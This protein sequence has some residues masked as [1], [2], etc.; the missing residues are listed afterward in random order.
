MPLVKTLTLL[1]NF[2]KLA[3]LTLA[4][5]Q[6]ALAA[7]NLVTNPGF[8][9]GDFTGWT[10]SGNTGFT[11]V[12]SQ[13][14]RSGNFAAFFG[15]IE[16]LGFI[17]QSL[18]TVPGE[19]Y[20][21]SYWLNNTSAGNNAFQVSWGG[22]IVGTSLINSAGFAYTQFSVPGLLATSGSTTLSFGFRNDEGFWNFDDVSV[23]AA[24]TPPPTGGG[25][26]DA[27]SSLILM[28]LGLAALA[29][30]RRCRA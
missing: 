15:P 16:T 23:T 21:L 14:P 20:Q 10:Q 3:T 13:A 27:G 18:T 5:V 2:A 8:E 24:G 1:C 17:S 9:T 7:D 30:V 4:S 19:I 22:D 28:V 6:V 26:P 11:G 12:D 25:V 29:G